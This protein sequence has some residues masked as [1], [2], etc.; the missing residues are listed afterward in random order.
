M[1]GSG[2]FEGY[3][4]LMP[5]AF[6]TC[7]VTA[8]AL[9]AQPSGL[10]GRTLLDEAAALDTSGA[11]GLEY[12]V[13]LPAAGDYV[14]AVCGCAPELT[15]A[16]LNA[17]VGDLV[18]G[19]GANASIYVGLNG[20]PA[21]RDGSGQVLPITGFADTPGYSWQSRWRDPL[22]GASGAVTISVPEPG[23]QTIN[24]WMA[25]DGLIVYSLRLTPLAQANI[26]PDAPVAACGPSALSD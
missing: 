7:P 11:P 6:G 5:L 25:D 9:A 20:A 4:W 17:P 13:D 15:S 26:E 22:A 3:A 14:V 23:S 19:A 16:D 21:A 8:D 24:L 1:Q 12:V 10:D 18:S 2:V